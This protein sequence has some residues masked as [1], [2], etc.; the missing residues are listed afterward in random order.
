MVFFEDIE[1]IENYKK[2]NNII[3]VIAGGFHF[4]W[5]EEVICEAVSFWMLDYL[6]GLLG[7]YGVYV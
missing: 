1:N 3:L 7:A 2:D 4:C 6:S 5:F